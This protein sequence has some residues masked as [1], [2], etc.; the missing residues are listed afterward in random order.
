MEPA[1]KLMDF[2]RLELSIGT[3]SMIHVRWKVQFIV[4]NLSNIQ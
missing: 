1:M 2:T 4:T 3:F